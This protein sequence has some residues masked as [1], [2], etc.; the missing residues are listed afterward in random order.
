MGRVTTAERVVRKVKAVSTDMGAVADALKSVLGSDAVHRGDESDL[1]E[2]RIFIPSGVPELD[3]VL[4]RKGRGYPVGRTIEI[5]GAS[6]TCKTGFAY[7]LLAKTHAMGGAGILYPT[8]GN[9]DTWLAERYGVDLAKLEIG[10]DPTVEGVF[11]SFRKAMRAVR[12]QGLLVG[13]IDSVAGLS[14]RAELEEETFDRDRAAQLRALMLSKAFR[15]LGA[16]IPRENALLFCINQVRDNTDGG[17]QSKPKPPG[18]HALRFYASIR[19]RIEIVQKVWA[20]VKGRRVVAGFHL[21]VTAEKNRLARPY[22][23]C[24]VL[25]DFD[26]GLLPVSEKRKDSIDKR[27]KRR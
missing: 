24:D 5:Y 25:L 19:L 6:A 26:R 17:A 14:T 9:V 8:E 3:L 22:Q 21:R 1:G 23:T 13:V 18:G 12:R 2:P 7:A 20:Q 15:K 27:R 4:D 11:A 10:D 16:E